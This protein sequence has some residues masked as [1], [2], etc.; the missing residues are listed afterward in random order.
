M[1]WV[2]GKVVNQSDC[3]ASL[4]NTKITDLVFADD[5]V[6]FAES[7]EVLVMALEALHEEGPVC[8]VVL[9]RQGRLVWPSTPLD[10]GAVV[11][12]TLRLPGGKGGFG[13]MLRAIG[14]QIEK[15]TNREACR[16][17][18]GRRLRDIN[19]EKRLKDF[20]SKK[21][22]RER[23]LQ[24]KK[25]LK[26][27]QLEETPRHTFQDESYFQQ[28]ELR[29]KNLYDS[30]DKAFDSKKSGSRT[31]TK[32]SMKEA[33]AAKPK[34]GRFLDDLDDSSSEEENNDDGAAARPQ[35]TSE[36]DSN[37]ST[38]SNAKHQQDNANSCR[39]KDSRS[40]DTK[41]NR[42]KEPVARIKKGGLMADLNESSSEEDEGNNEE[43]EAKPQE[44]SEENNKETEASEEN[45]KE[46]EAKPQEASEENNKE[47]I[48][49]NKETEA[50]PQEAS[51]ENN[52]ETEAKP[53]EAS[54]ENNKE[55]EAKPQEASEEN[56]KEAEAK[57][58]EASEE[59][60]KET[61]A[62]PQEAIE[63][64]NKETEASDTH[65]CTSN[66][67]SSTESRKEED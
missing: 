56:N 58:Q 54:E 44:A 31:A 46:A 5:A 43:T 52:K 22:D 48:E 62:K 32:R 28:R 59:N 42:K 40:S 49:N 19:E 66:S 6:L 21:A 51:E 64:N 12:A 10:G 33:P 55:T 30:L 16:D 24:E 35:E 18:S 67:N 57:P 9:Q 41:A 61:E 37:S 38:G 27:K 8:N 34:K 63:E 65:R 26:F 53:Q 29:E 25:K 23:E 1:D 20:I 4:G 36:S 50:K 39:V 3:G 15:T 7:L 60:N 47:T 17:L 14:A 11:V 45:S 2:L 13:S